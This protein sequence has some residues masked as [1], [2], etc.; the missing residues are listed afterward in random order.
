VPR[1][2]VPLEE[3]GHRLTCREEPSWY[4]DQQAGAIPAGAVGVQS[5]AVSESGERQRAQLDDTVARR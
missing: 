4:L 3:D 1:P 2:F 5:A